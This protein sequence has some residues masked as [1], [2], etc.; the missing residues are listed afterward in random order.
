MSTDATKKS[1]YDGIERSKSSVSFQTCTCAECGAVYAFNDQDKFFEHIGKH[2][3]V[4][5]RAEL[6][7]QYYPY[8]Y[9]ARMIDWSTLQITAALEHDDMDGRDLSD[10]LVHLALTDAEE[11][12]K[13]VLRE[14]EE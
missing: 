12:V 11:M 7:Q 5:K 9:L 3:K 8:A 2:T 10:E 13:E 6:I 14:K 4:D 1:A